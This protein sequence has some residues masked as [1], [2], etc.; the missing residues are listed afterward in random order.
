M[1]RPVSRHSYHYAS[2]EQNR[3]SFG[4]EKNKVVKQSDDG[5]L[6]MIE[7]NLASI[8]SSS[9]I[10]HSEEKFEKRTSGKKFA[11]TIITLSRDD[12]TKDDNVT[13]RNKGLARAIDFSPTA[14]AVTN[15]HEN[16][17]IGEEAI[18]VAPHQEVCMDCE[19]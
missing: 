4:C 5:S 7:A 14:N 1:E 6:T 2:Y 19:I 17:D 12:T 3:H 15:D 8:P 10:G 18:I 13:F 9:R 11:S 16:M